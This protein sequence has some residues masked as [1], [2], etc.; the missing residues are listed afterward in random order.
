MSNDPCPLAASDL[1]TSQVGDEVLLYDFATHKAHCATR[2]AHAVL[3]RCDGKTSIAA[4]AKALTLP[5]DDVER[6]L[7]DLGQ[8]GLLRRSNVDLARRRAMKQV[9]ATVGL[10][11]A[12]PMVWS[13][14]A[15]SKAQAASITASC[16]A[17]QNCMGNGACCGAPGAPV[18]TCEINPSDMIS[19]CTGSGSAAPCSADPAAVCQ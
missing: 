9:A 5:A 8:A 16:V 19:A 3:Q 11:V 15:P 18:M 13:I 14:V 6:A 2:T 4:I 1:I 17:P 12:A 7:A 10:S